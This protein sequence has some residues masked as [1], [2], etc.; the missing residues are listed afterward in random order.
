MP[1]A[2]GCPGT[3]P[4]SRELTGAICRVPSTPFSHAPGYALPV[5]LCRFR[6]RSIRGGYFPDLAG[7][8][9]N[10]ISP[11]TPWKPSPPAGPGL[12]TWFPSATRFR[13]ALGAGSPCADWPGAGT[14]GLSAG[15][16][17]ALLSLLMSA[18]SLPIP[19]ALLTEHLHR[20]TERSATTQ[21]T[22]ARCWM[23]DNSISIDRSRLTDLD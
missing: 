5:H 6:V 7:S 3:G 18:F 1:P 8:Q 12:L 17:L 20:P 9:D 23:S 21:K 14:L 10:P 13:L 15:E 22:D 16:V 11:D 19:P 2:P 4:P